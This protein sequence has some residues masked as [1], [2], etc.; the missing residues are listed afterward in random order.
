MNRVLVF[1]GLFVAAVAVLP[2]LTASAGT[3]VYVEQEDSGR[4]ADDGDT[5]YRI[6][7]TVPTEGEYN[8]PLRSNLVTSSSTQKTVK[9][10]PETWRVLDKKVVQK[11]LKD[12]RSALALAAKLRTN[13]KQ[14]APYPSAMGIEDLKKSK[15]KKPGIVANERDA[16][17]NRKKVEKNMEDVKKEAD[18]ANKKQAKEEEK[19]TAATAKKPAAPAEEPERKLLKRKKTNDREPGQRVFN[20]PE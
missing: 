17:Q 20:L 15:S 18:K 5:G 9:G 16:E 14:P 7:N 11:R 1:L 19:K 3:K 13:L 2:A 6:Y 10:I 12:T 8:I 4:S